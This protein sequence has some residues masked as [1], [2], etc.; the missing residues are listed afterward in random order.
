MDSE[1]YDLITCVHGLHYIGDKLALIRQ[2]ASWLT[3]NGRFLANLDLANFLRPDGESLGRE[4]ARQF[5]Y[6]GLKFDRRRHLLT[7]AGEQA[8][9]FEYEYVGA[10][11]Q[12]GPNYS[13]QEVVNSYYDRAT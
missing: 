12:A 6:K 4:M 1:Q 11:D 8:I 13:G 9:M 5:E 3:A 2:A 10:D 7:C